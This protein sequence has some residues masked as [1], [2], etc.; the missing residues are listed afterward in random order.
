MTAYQRIYDAITFRL[1]RSL[2]NAASTHMHPTIRPLV[3]CPNPYN[4]AEER[5][6][7]RRRSDWAELALL[8]VFIPTLPTKVSWGE[9]HAGPCRHVSP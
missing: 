2:E 5:G 8:V 3:K 1:L 6:S 7:L 4:E 9:G